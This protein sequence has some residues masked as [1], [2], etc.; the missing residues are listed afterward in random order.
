[1]G[2]LTS[3]AGPLT[4]ATTERVLARLR[5]Y[6][7]QESPSGDTERC[8]RLAHVVASDLRDLGAQVSLLPAPGQG[9]HV[10]AQFPP[11]NESEHLLILGHLDTVH[12]VGTLSQLPFAVNEER[13]TGPGIFD[14]KAGLALMIEALAT[15]RRSG[16][17]TARP[18]RMLVTCD[19]EVGSHT[20]RA[21][22]EEQARGAHAVLVPEPALPGGRAKTSRKGVATYRLTTHGR[23]AHA[24]IEPERGVN[25]IDE[26][27]HQLLAVQALAEPSLGT[28]VLVSTVNG[29]TVSNVV[30]AQATATIDARFSLTTEGERIQRALL[31]L[32]PHD[33]RAGLDVQQVDTRPPL[34]RTPAVVVLFERARALAAALGFALGEGDTGGGS[35]GCL[36]AALGIATLDGIGPQGGGAHAADEHIRVQDLPFRLAFYASLLEQ[37]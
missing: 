5:R 8:T 25:A 28:T 22:I 30:P 19:E 21:V 37:L 18:V 33:A 12:P 13:A 29:G 1:M 20:A 10:L 23:A 35:D 36:T 6:V 32:T 4:D 24:G 14:M 16:R 7:E 26:L 11:V 31:A 27:V 3:V 17:S 9:L 2:D 34:E 15:L